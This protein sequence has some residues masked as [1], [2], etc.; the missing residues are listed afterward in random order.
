MAATF[1]DLWGTP[2][3]GREKSAHRATA[4]LRASAI[5]VLAAAVA[6]IAATFL[7]LHLTV[8]YLLLGAGIVGF[9]GVI[10]GGIWLGWAHGL[11]WY[12]A[13]GRTARVAGRLLWSAIWSGA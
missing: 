6:L 10:G 8:F 7:N 13:I 5:T 9:A 11:A 3:E 2:L 12:Q 1:D 4:L